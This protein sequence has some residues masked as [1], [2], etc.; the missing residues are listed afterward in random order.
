VKVPQQATPSIR[1]PERRRPH[2]SVMS[3]NPAVRVERF[4]GPQRSRVRLTLRSIVTLVE[5]TSA[6]SALPV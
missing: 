1:R 4:S 3:V 6:G 2:E 5:D